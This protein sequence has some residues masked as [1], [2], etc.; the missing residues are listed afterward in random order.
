MSTRLPAPITSGAADSAAH[1]VE[2]HIKAGSLRVHDPNASERDRDEIQKTMLGSD[3]LDVEHYR[4]IVFRSTGLE[5]T[6]DALV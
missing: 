6:Q 2:L 3:V 1:H 5:P 4:Q